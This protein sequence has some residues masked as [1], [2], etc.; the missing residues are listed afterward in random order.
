MAPAERELRGDA[1]AAT[2]SALPELEPAHR[3]LLFSSFGAE[4]PTAPAVQ[5][6]AARGHTLLL[7]FLTESHMDA[8]EFHPDEPLVATTYGPGEPPSA[9]AAPPSAIDA[10]VVPGLAFDR[11]GFRLGYGG[12]HYDRYLRRVRPD[13]VRI[14]ICFHE[15]LIERVPAGPGDERVHLVVTD[16]E[17]VDCRGAG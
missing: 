1:V 7:P 12:G 17:V 5:L 8:S 16:R 13:A 9:A 10:V 3:I 4:I 15:Q 6:L 2:L 14:G 11:R